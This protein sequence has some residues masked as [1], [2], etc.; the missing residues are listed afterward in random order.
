MSLVKQK[1]KHRDAAEV[2]KYTPVEYK[3]YLRDIKTSA[4][5]RAKNDCRGTC[6]SHRL[7]SMRHSLAKPNQ[8][9]NTI[10]AAG[11]QTGL[12]RSNSYYYTNKCELLSLKEFNILLERA[13]SQQKRRRQKEEREERKRLIEAVEDCI[14]PKNKVRLRLTSAVA[15]RLRNLIDL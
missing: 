5:S 6:S 8:Q 9:R 14:Q 1:N 12:P 7:R 3:E 11:M 15:N 10:E 2:L 4:G 13:Q